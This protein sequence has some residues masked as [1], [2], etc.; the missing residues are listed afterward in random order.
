MNIKYKAGIFDLDGVIVDTAKYHY[1]AWK[2]LAHELGFEF[3]K[4]KNQLL[5]GVSR[6]RSLE[7]L[8]SIGGIEA[9]DET[10]IRMAK[11]KNDEYV[12]LIKQ[13]DRSEMLPKVESFL[14]SL[15]NYGIK[16][17][18]GSA[19][20]N[21]PLILQRLD[22]EKLFDA[23]IDGNKVSKAKP[24]PEVFLKAAKE[25]GID[26][27][28]C[29]VFEDAEAGLQAAKLAGMYAVGIGKPDQLPS[30][31]IVFPGLYGVDIKKMFF[32]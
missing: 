8:L 23:V 25:V 16:T 21:A 2:N 3:S 26:P 9:D 22:I 28:N 15:R 19:S 31:D 1:I 17:V 14:R 29:V 30:A 6:E 32:S 24:D 4:T 10:K 20:K 11:Q 12:R 5:K 18:L 27:V 7:I 13:L